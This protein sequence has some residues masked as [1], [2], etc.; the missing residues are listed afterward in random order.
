MKL[1]YQLV[2]GDRTAHQ[3]SID[4]HVRKMDARRRRILRRRTQGAN[5][6][7][8]AREEGCTHGSI[9]SVINRSM[10]AV[11]KAIAGE[12]RYAHGHPG[13]YGSKPQPE[14]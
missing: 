9:Q 8:I 11:R 14:A 5:L 10:R 2:T 12:P 3:R 4:A 1:L 13:R 6:K 7:Q